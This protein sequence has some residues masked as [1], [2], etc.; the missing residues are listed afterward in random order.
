MTGEISG[1]ESSGLEAS[2]VGESDV[3]QQ[4]KRRLRVG[5]IGFAV[6]TVLAI[7]SVLMVLYGVPMDAIYWGIFHNFLDLDVYRHGGSFVVQGLPL[8]DGPVFKGMMFTYTPFAG[9]L[10]TVWAVL[11]FQ[12]AIVVWSV[13]NVAALFAVIVLCWKYL[14]YR[15]DA[16]AYAVS[17]LATVIFLFMEPVRTT[18]WLGQ[19]NI[20]L[21]LLIVW[22]LGRDEKSR[23]RGI[24][25]GIAAGVKL[26]PAFFW[27][28][29]FVTKQ[30][31]ALVTAVL[32]FA[33][34]VALGFIVMYH[35]AYT[36]WTGTL[37]DSE[38]VGRSD[39]PSNQSVSGLIARLTHTPE[40]S[41]VLV[42]GLSALAA[43][44]GLGAAWVAYRQ[45]Q[46][47]LGITL[48][49]LTATVVSPFSWGHHWVWFVPLVILAAH[50]AMASRK[51][52]AWI[53]PVVFL[54]PVLNWSRTWWDPTVFPGTDRFVGMGLFMLTVPDY[55]S[56][57]TGAI[58][59]WVFVVAA[60]S[61]LILFGWKK[62]AVPEPEAEVTAI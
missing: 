31:R 8:Y 17:V 13:L 1:S 52:W 60:V 48:T 14:G 30:W 53:A 12:Q 57:L 33:A 38:R 29:L 6:L 20:F 26:T 19:I 36:Y 54:L 44:L 27:A 43:C 61:T 47:L 34:T 39:A 62:W 35:D 59:L 25:A 51:A 49:G 9:I 7:A 56:I 45:G 55:L 15:L 5:V 16:K 42:L 32:T 4:S 37:F 18:L 11:T 40:P 2:S 23:L 22:D 58:Y 46:K 3:P 21:L 28:Y 24:G 50:Y 10:F 41:Q